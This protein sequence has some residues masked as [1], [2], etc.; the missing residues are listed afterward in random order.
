MLPRTV[1]VDQNGM[2]AHVQDG[3]MTH[4]ALQEIIEGLL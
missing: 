1:I 4:E 3:S 2:V